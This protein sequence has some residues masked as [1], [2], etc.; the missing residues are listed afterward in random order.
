MVGMVKNERI[1][2]WVAEIDVGN[3]QE[4]REKQGFSQ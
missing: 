2:Y 4:G 1:R 3:P